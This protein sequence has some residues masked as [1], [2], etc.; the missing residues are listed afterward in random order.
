M[1]NKLI[2]YIGGG[3]MS[4]IFSAGVVTGLQDMNFYDKIEA[5]Y[6]GSAGAI[7]AAYFLSKQTKLGSSIYY[8]YFCLHNL[9]ISFIIL[10]VTS[11]SII[12]LIFL[13]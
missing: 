9:A 11:L 6:G 4:G 13:L 1:N 5:I 2:I 8:V 10:S 12:L 7:N 3:S